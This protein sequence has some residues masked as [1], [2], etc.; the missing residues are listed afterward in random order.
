MSEVKFNSEGSSRTVERRRQ[1]ASDALYF[2]TPV[3][4]D[5]NHTNKEYEVKM[6]ESF[7]C[8]LSALAHTVVSSTFTFKLEGEGSLLF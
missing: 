5:R 6:T 4:V 2:G 7:G 8:S 3:T 1:S